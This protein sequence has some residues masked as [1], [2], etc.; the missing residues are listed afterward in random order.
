MQGT[1][2]ASAMDAIELADCGTCGKPASETASG[3]HA[4]IRAGWAR[5]G[6]TY[7]TQC[8]ECWNA[9]VAEARRQRK[10][11]LVARPECEACG[12][13]KV[14]CTLRPNARVALDV[15]RTCARNA[16]RNLAQPMLF[17]AGWAHVTR[18]SL[19]RAARP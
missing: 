9:S 17:A 14:T 8:V 4:A 1:I 18:E 7:S 2:T 16:Q 15:C 3:R 12:R 11:E 5:T 19:I 10:A 6:Y 13:R